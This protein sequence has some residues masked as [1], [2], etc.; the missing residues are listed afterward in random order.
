MA[1]LRI[2]QYP[3]PV[4][5]QPTKPVENFNDPDLQKLI[6]DMLETMHHAN[7]AGLAATQVGVAQQI[8]VIDMSERR[9]NSLVN[10]LVV[11]NPQILEMSGQR[12]VEEGCLSIQDFSETVPRAS[13]VRVQFQDRQGN[14][15]EMEALDHL[16]HVFQH[17][18]DHLNGKLFIHR[19]SNVKRHFFERKYKK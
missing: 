15:Q 3:E 17:E 7:G 14:M 11:I 18:I 2:T 16:A 1:L 10:T 4:L 8:A 6:D 19:L 12:R 9:A 5:L 13:R